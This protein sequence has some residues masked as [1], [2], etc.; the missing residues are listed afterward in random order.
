MKRVYLCNDNITGIF[1]AIYDAWK[2]ERT[3]ENAGVGIKG[4]LEQ[5]LFCE[6]VES[7]ESETKAQ[8]VK[9]LI[10]RNLGE[11]AYRNICQAAMSKDAGKGTA[12]WQMMQEARRIRDSRRIMDHLSHPGV[13]RVF[14][15]G[16]RVGNEA[17]RF[18]EFVRFREL[19]NG[20]L[21]AVIEPE[22]QI[23]VCIADHF[24]DRL[25]REDW[26]IY[27]K[28]HKTFLVHQREK[29]WFLLHGASVD[30]ERLGRYSGE[31]REFERLWKG[32]CGSIS[33]AEREN[34]MLQRR[35]FPIRYRK[36]VT[37]F[38]RK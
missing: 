32:F 5:E 17:Y 12:I 29:G 16:R 9:R 7:R 14:E 20:I 25:P 2:E 27:D 4:C 31:E 11:D 26:M 23:L 22:N 6:Y 36:N 1:S 21:C 35:H 13:A 37:E 3:Q 38:D 19:D 18:L 15:L 10:D 8:A 28:S 30:E 24:A 34:P 33:I